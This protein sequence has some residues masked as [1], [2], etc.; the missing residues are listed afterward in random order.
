MANRP[1]ILV[2]PN[3]FGKSSLATVFKSLKSNKIELDKDDYYMNDET[4]LPVLKLKLSTGE[5]LEASR[6]ANSISS[7]FRVY[8]INSQL[9]PKA[10]AQSYGGRTIAKASMDIKPTVIIPTIP[11]KVKFDFSLKQMKQD[12]GNSGKLLSDISMLFKDFDFVDKISKKVQFN[13]FKLKR[14]L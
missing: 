11:Q 1:N 9:K 5:A 14:A 3:G 12:F 6:D 4:N 10:I 13:E 7:Y 2:A 8:V